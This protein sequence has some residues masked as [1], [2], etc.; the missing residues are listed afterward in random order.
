MSILL[1]QCDGNII[2]LEEISKIENISLIE[3]M[4]NDKNSWASAVLDQINNGK[5]Y[6]FLTNKKYDIMI[7]IGAHVGMVSSFFAPICNKIYAIEPT[8]FNFEI[9]KIINQ[10]INNIIPNFCAISNKT[11]EEE[12]FESIINNTQNSLIQHHPVRSL[13]KTKCYNLLD[14]FNNNDIKIA[15]LVKMDVEGAEMKI[16]LNGNF[17]KLNGKIREIFVEVHNI[18]EGE[19]ANDGLTNQSLIFDKLNK[20]D[21]LCEKRNDAVYGVWNK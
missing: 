13:G 15:D 7:D 16:I 8:L 14:F 1:K 9:L 5:I 17:E 4:F 19:Y 12:F 20:L 6:D 2:N 3:I 18:N 10:K 21:Y 11:G